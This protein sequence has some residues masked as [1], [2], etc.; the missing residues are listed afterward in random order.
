MELTDTIRDN[1]KDE[2]VM[3]NND[4]NLNAGV[5]VGLIIMLLGMPSHGADAPIIQ[6]GLPGELGVLISSKDASEIADSSHTAADIQFMTLM[7]PHHDQALTMSKMAPDRTNNK[8]VLEIAGRIEKSQADEIAFMRQWLSERGASLTSIETHEHHESSHSGHSGHWGHNKMHGMASENQLSELKNSE[9][10][11]FDQM[12]LKLMIAHHDGAIKMVKDL[13]DQPGSAY[14][15]SLNEFA[16]DVSNDQTVE[17]ERMN[18]MLVGLSDDPRA[19]LAGGLFDAEY[20]SKN[21]NLVVSLPKPDGFYDPDNVGGLKAE[22]SADEVSEKEKK[23]LKSVAKSSRSG[24]YPM[25]SFDNTDMAFNG[26]TLVVGNYHG[27]NIYDIENAKNP[28]LISSVVCPGGQ[29]DVSIVEHLLIMS[30]EQSRGRLDCGREG[31]SED[32]SEERFRGIRIFDI[33]NLE[34]PIQVGAVQTCRGSHTHS[35]VSGPTDDGAILV[36][37]SGTSRIRDQEELDG[38]VDSTPGDTQTS[39]F[40]IDVIEIPI[41]E[42]SKAKII[43]SPTVFADAET[44]SLAGLWRGGD[45][46]DDTQRTSRTDQCHDIT[47][48][49]SLGIAAGACSGNGILF[50]ISDPR[51]PKRIHDV[52]D[53][54]FAY[55]HSATFNNAG[56]KVLFTD[57]WGGGGRARCR[58]W[59]PI[60]WGADAIYDIVNGELQAKS[61]YKMPAPQL[62]TE[63]CVAHNGSI[64]PIPGRDIFVQAWYQGGISIM[65]FT[66]SENP[67]EIAYF[68]RGPMLEETLLSGG[69]WSTYYYKG[70]I[71]GTEMVRGLDILELIPS[72]HLSKHEIAAAIGAFPKDGPTNIFNPQQ[73][74]EMTWPITPTLALAYLDQVQREGNIGRQDEKEL[75]NSL[76]MLE[77]GE[78]N[79]T[80]KTLALINSYTP[81]Q[82][83]RFIKHTEKTEALQKVLREIS[84]I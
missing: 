84:S 72:D 47:I 53:S 74:V 64:I 10:T 43:D 7:I 3:Q 38:C 49:P 34:F 76:L 54:G 67:F 21:M 52:Q 37:N 15:S 73:Q 2:V 24:R 46:G 70:F 8:E 79:K 82:S 28:K 63:N 41:N 62:E 45:H 26:N 66:D 5:L 44:G 35:V 65:D 9:A 59:D 31:V 57:E 32:V 14:D 16:S 81:E 29:G 42:P 12:F 55:W 4:K 1:F 25:L 58:A 23:Q 71:F 50:D 36:Y 61:Y 68:D 40:R 80:K 39:L 48:F 27:F 78:G 20:A 77:K 11:K 18:Q 51:K 60:T 13:R 30:V 83:D 19:G 33:S 56:T 22:K 69:F 6:P 17:I 75:R